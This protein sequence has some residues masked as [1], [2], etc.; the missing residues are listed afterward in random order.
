[1]AGAP[2]T[3]AAPANDAMVPVRSMFITIA[4]TVRPAAIPGPEMMSGTLTSCSGRTWQQRQAMAKGA[5]GGC[6][7]GTG[8]ED[9][10]EGEEDKEQEE[11]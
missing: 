7:S 8:G 10:E 5:G 1:M 2:G 3:G 6:G 4:D 11:D 9:G